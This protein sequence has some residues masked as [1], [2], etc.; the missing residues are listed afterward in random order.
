MPAE[1]MAALISL[2]GTASDPSRASIELLAV[3]P[4]RSATRGG[5]LMVAA[6]CAKWRRP[7]ASATPSVAALVGQRKV[8]VHLPMKKE[9]KR[10]FGA[11][12]AGPRAVGE[13]TPA[14]LI[15]HNC[16]RGLAADARSAACR[17]FRVPD[18][19]RAP[20]AAAGAGRGR[21]R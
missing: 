14:P 4:R 15:A 2:N 16:H 11:V 6:G 5:P 13:V 19:S 10:S 3:E 1:I 9:A 17:C 12:S 18:R 20:R 8:T 7:S 21:I